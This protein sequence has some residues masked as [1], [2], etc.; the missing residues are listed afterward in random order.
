MAPTASSVS[1]DR[2]RLSKIPLHEVEVGA[3]FPAVAP[4]ASTT[5][6]GRSTPL[7]RAS[8]DR[9]QPPPHVGEIA[10]LEIDHAPRD[11]RRPRRH[12][13]EVSDRPRRGHGPA[14]APRARRRRGPAR[15]SEHH[16]DSRTRPVNSA[17]PGRLHGA[18]HGRRAGG[19]L[20]GAWTRCAMTSVSGLR[21]E[22]VAPRL[23][24]RS[25]SSSKFSM[26]PLCTTA[27]SAPRRCAVRVCPGWG[28]RAFAQ[29][30]V[31]NA[32]GAGQRTPVGLRGRSGDPCGADQPVELR[33]RAGDHAQPRGV[34]SRDTRAGGCR[35]SLGCGRTLPRAGRADDAAHGSIQSFFFDCL[36]GRFQPAFVTWAGARTSRV[37]GGVARDGAAAAI[38]A[39][40]PMSPVPP[41]PVAADVRV[42]ADHRAGA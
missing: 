7:A 33:C 27:I 40:A 42:V 10:L 30:R 37:R 39:A 12:E 18:Q 26:M 3:E 34:R 24:N 19:V 17:R 41:A 32:R 28:R 8:W 21:D 15:A 20:S 35:R 29:R 25:R 36:T 6:H 16:R 2:P 1:R 23:Q 14:A 22:R 4:L 13:V 11:R 31:R 9:E 5:V 38:V